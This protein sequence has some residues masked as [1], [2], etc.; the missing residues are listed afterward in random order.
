[1]P[2]SR[3]TGT[4]VE[5]SRCAWSHLSPRTPGF[6]AS[7]SS[8]TRIALPVQTERV[9]PL[10]GDRLARRQ[11]LVR[12]LRAGSA[13]L[14][15]QHNLHLPPWDT[16]AQFSRD[17]PSLRASRTRRVLD[18]QTQV[19]VTDAHRPSTGTLCFDEFPP[20]VS[21]SVS[22]EDGI[23]ILPSVRACFYDLFDIKYIIKT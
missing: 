23:L 18:T 13:V 19:C 8:P 20:L 17:P 10:W 11:G 5:P 12:G 3:L 2:S 14:T 16:G 21:P 9:R 6:I 1:M 7:R 4:L 22:P 15:L